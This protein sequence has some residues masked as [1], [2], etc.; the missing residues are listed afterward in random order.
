VVL[1]DGHLLGHFTAGSRTLLI[2]TAVPN[3]ANA[4]GELV[5]AL[6]VLCDSVRNAA[7][8]LPVIEVIDGGP[9]QASTFAAV[10]ELAGFVKDYRGFTA[11]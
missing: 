4:P 7:R 8:K 11:R 1:S 5:D 9:A 3:D 6:R 2:F 10:L